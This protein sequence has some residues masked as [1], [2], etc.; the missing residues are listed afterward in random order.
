MISYIEKLTNEILNGRKIT[1][2]EALNL[3]NIDNNDLGIL[4]VLFENAN[5]IRDKFNGKKA[6]LCTI[7]N[8]KSGKCSENCTFCAQSSHYNTGVEEYPLVSYDD[9]YKRAK[10]MEA[11]GAHR[12]SLV[13]SG[14]GMTD[15][16]LEDIIDIYK[17]LKENTTI[18]L[19]TSLGIISY[20]Q[21][22]KLVEAGVTMYHHN[23]ETSSDYYKNVCTTHS[24]DERIETIRNVK[25]AGM[26]V[27]CGGII[28]MGESIED[29]IKMAFEIRELEVESIP[30]NILNPIKGTPL[31]NNES[32]EPMEILKTMAVYRFIIP[33][34]YIR[35]AGG[36]MLLED[37][38]NI[39]L[40][41][42]V[43]AL[44]VGNY[45]TTIG[46]DI[47]QDKKMVEE[48]GLEIIY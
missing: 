29:R 6:D 21:A 24:Y 4:N 32:L 38:Q 44:L 5:K 41:A 17:R 14:R 34:S 25:K 43:N 40:R 16:E 37:T 3:I 1:Y 31:E 48:E 7:M 8:A 15:K 45:L 35:Y 39:G 9:A 36:R 30:I 2:E 27:C 18:N 12:F 13:T 20:E 26:E 47:D 22:K 11:K 46:N 19:C 42:G 33:K 23:V 28:G 10:E